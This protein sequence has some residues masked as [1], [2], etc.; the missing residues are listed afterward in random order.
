MKQQRKS[1]PYINDTGSVDG[2]LW[3]AKIQKQYPH[4]DLNL[5]RTSLDLH[6]NT[7]ELSITPFGEPCIQQGI[8]IAD[9]LAA[10]DQDII[11][12]ASALIYPYVQYTDLS[13]Q[14][15]AECLG[16]SVAQLLQGVLQ[17]ETV[18][19]LAL[20]QIKPVRTRQQDENF[21]KMLLTM[22]SDV[23]VVLLKLAEQLSILQVLAYGDERLQQ[24]YAL[25]T[26]AVYAPLANRLGLGYLKWQLEDWSFRFLEPT[27]YKKIANLLDERREQRDS[28]VVEVI[29]DIK[30]ILQSNAIEHFEVSGRAK[31]IYGIYRKMKR[32]EVDYNKVYDSVAVRV[33]LPCVADCYTVLSLVHECWEQISHEFDDYIAKPKENGYQSL[34]TAVI[35]SN[36]RHFEV[37][38]RTFEMHQTAELGL[39]AHWAYKEGRAHTGQ[40][41]DQAQWLHQILAWKSNLTVESEGVEAVL[42]TVQKSRIYVF[43][44]NGEVVDLVQGATVLD[45]A[46]R[47]HS[48]VG[49]RCRGAKVNGKIVPLTYTLQTAEQVEILTA[50]NHTPSRD[51]LNP[52]MG[53][54]KTS[55]ARAKVSHWFRQQDEMKK[56]VPGSIREVDHKL[57]SNEVPQVQKTRKIKTPMTQDVVIEGSENLIIRMAKCCKPVPGDPITGYITQGFGISIHQQQC[58]NILAMNENQKTRLVDAA[59]DDSPQGHYAVELSVIAEDRARLMHDMTALLANRCVNCTAIQSH[60]NAV[61]E[62]VRFRMTLELQQREEINAMIDALKQINGVLEVI[63]T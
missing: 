10:L 27:A 29:S 60:L 23:R 30:L 39:A 4:R 21:R 9:Q 17:M 7:V 48:E 22:A 49:H 25:E 43:T 1:F 19:S 11:T 6:N 34:H 62:Q 59:W 38:I 14:D 63:R 56:T 16:S 58:A 41:F 2:S 33:L 35:A 3:L 40:E 50:K 46:Y 54:L 51:W 44:P 47:V 20:T 53:Y 12:L 45:F 31:H 37:Q 36:G 52:K 18:H 5:L 55:R 26:R 24:R 8:A 61:N 32:K 42:P 57:F 28:F 13:V 15:V